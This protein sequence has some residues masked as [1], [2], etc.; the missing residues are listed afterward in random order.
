MAQILVLL[1]QLPSRPPRKPTINDGPFIQAFRSISSSLLSNLLEDIN[2]SSRSGGDITKYEIKRPYVSG[3]RRDLLGMLTLVSGLC[4][5]IFTLESSRT[6]HTTRNRLYNTL[7]NLKALRN[8]EKMAEKCFPDL[9]KTKFFV[10]QTRQGDSNDRH[11][12]A[13]PRIPWWG[14]MS[15]GIAV[16]SS[17]EWMG[18]RYIW[19]QA[20]RNKYKDHGKWLYRILI[21]MRRRVFDWWGRVDD[22]FGS[23][24]EVCYPWAGVYAK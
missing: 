9:F 19:R 10:W 7:W 12:E 11:K 20:K 23:C 5:D 8:F 6:H 22:A 18:L 1:Y 16:A 2:R 24:W 21:E 15:A 3:V 17:D 13:C 4:S 14:R